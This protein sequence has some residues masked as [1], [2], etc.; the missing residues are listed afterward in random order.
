[1]KNIEIVCT[2]TTINPN[3]RKLGVE[4]YG[5]KDNSLEVENGILEINA[6][7]AMPEM[8]I[9]FLT[10]AGMKEIAE[11]AGRRVTEGAILRRNGRNLQREVR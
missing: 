9:P 8:E 4:S 10:D 6:Y 2:S 11:N 7:S 1:M 3:E 5:A